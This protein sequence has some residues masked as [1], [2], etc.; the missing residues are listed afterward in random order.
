MRRRRYPSHPIPPRR[1]TPRLVLPRRAAAGNAPDDVRASP[2][3]FADVCP[4][5][6]LPGDP[7][8]PASSSCIRQRSRRG[9]DFASVLPRRVAALRPG[10]LS[11]S[12]RSGETLRRQR[13]PSR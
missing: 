7:P 5:R 11:P 4:R 2:R 10:L 1:G 9:A 8:H 6:D 13:D 3:R 12:C